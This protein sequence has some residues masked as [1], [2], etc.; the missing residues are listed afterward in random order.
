M[1]RHG[2]LP[3]WL[4]WVSLVM[5]ILSVTPVGFFVFL[6]LAVW[7]PLVGILLALRE[8]AAATV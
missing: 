7:I 1:L 3:K 2:V 5:A 4:G 8:R 6:S